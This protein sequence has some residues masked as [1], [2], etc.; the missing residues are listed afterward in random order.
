MSNTSAVSYITTNSIE[1]FVK[2]AKIEKMK[3]LSQ[4][5]ENSPKRI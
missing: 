5:P 1:K 4:E 3:Y 2:N